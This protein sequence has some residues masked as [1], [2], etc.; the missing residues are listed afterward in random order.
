MFR[1]YVSF[2]GCTLPKTNMDTQ[3]DGLEKE[4]PLKK[5]N[6]GI[7]VSFFVCNCFYNDILV[8][9]NWSI[10]KK[11]FLDGEIRLLTF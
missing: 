3:T 8:G 9:P 4:L 11:V 1:F 6:F 7:Y 5:D 2:L 10:V